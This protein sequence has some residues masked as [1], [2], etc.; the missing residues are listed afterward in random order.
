MY[1]LKGDKEIMIKLEENNYCEHCGETLTEC[2]NITIHDNDIYH[3]ECLPEN[4]KEIK[5]I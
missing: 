4:L 1:D 5:D 2:D 3:D